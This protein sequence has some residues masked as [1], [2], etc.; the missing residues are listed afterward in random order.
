M[1]TSGNVFERPPAPESISSS[2]PGIAMRHGEGLRREP[3]SSTIPSPRFSRN[4]DAWNSMCRTGGTYSRNCAMETPR[5]A[6]SELHFGKFTDPEDFQCWKVT[7]KT[8]VCVSTS[9]PELTMSWINEVEKGGSMDDLMTSQ[10]IKGESFLDFL[11]CLIGGLRLRCERS[12]PCPL[13]GKESVLKISE[14]KNTI[15]S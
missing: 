2:L 10:S 9:T 1:G 8:E 7:F 4:P 13:S 6:I 14:L 12:S 3:Q 11:R 5:C 15:D